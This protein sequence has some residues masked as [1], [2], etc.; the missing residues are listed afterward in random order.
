M[1]SSLVTI[2]V[3]F[4]A[5]IPVLYSIFVINMYSLHSDI[6]K[7]HFRFTLLYPII[8]YT[9]VRYIEVRLFY[10]LEIGLYCRCS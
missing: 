6:R 5:K 7:K 10:T 3:A 1:Q 2:E 9:H 8:H 4:N